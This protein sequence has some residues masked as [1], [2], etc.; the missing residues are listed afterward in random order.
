M[1]ERLSA[2]TAKGEA[3]LFD[4]VR[5]RHGT[6]TTVLISHRL[7]NVRHADVIYVL[8][9]GHLVGSGSHDELIASG[10]LYA[11]L[12]GLQSESYR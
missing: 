8:E 2:L 7:A 6:T 12:F 11:D 3:A 5:A 10:G 9:A 4:A 1:D